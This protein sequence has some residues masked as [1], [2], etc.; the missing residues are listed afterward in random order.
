MVEDNKYYT[1]EIEELHI[2]MECFYD[3]ERHKIIS[4]NNLSKEALNHITL[5]W[6]DKSDIEDLGWKFNDYLTEI[7]VGDLFYKDTFQL[8]LVPS[9][10]EGLV[11]YITNNDDRELFNGLVKNKSELR[12]LMQMLSIK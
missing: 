11:V 10:H 9:T 6:L 1:P 12:K 3:G 2:N 8:I 7:R 5:K 4:S